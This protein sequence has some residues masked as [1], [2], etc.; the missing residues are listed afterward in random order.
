MAKY[1]KFSDS[2]KYCKGK[3]WKASGKLKKW[4]NKQLLEIIRNLLMNWWNRYWI[5]KNIIRL[6]STLINIRII[7]VGETFA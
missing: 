6:N 4:F 2:E 1:Y 3:V 7:N 5:S